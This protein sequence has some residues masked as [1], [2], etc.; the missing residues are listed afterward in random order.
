M[1]DNG[2]TAEK[3]LFALLTDVS[4]MEYL[5]LEVDWTAPGATFTAGDWTA[6]V[7]LCPRGAPFD[8][9]TASRAI[10]RFTPDAD[11]D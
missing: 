4:S 9:D 5:I 6:E 10:G 2:L 8:P 7:A 1:S 11:A 3:S